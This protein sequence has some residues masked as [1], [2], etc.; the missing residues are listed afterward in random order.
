MDFVVQSIT[1]LAHLRAAVLYIVDISEQCGHTI[2][3]QAALF[4]SIKPLFSGK[5][6][7]IV[8]N[9]LDVTPYETLSEEDKKVLQEMAIESLKT[10][11]PGKDLQ[12]CL[13]R[14]HSCAI[15]SILICKKPSLERRWLQSMAPRTRL[16]MAE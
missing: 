8:L 2:Q 13:I 3:Q 7:L 9:K 11:T 15:S 16:A 14:L 1:A 10:S 4:Y 12:Y 5:P 6:L